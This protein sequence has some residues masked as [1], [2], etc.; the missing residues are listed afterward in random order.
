[1]RLVVTGERSTEKPR[2]MRDHVSP[3][4]SEA[5]QLFSEKQ[6]S[7]PPVLLKYAGFAWVR[8]SISRPNRERGGGRVGSCKSM[9]YSYRL[10]KISQ[11]IW[12]AQ[13]RQRSIEPVML[14]SI[15]R[16]ES[17]CLE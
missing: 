12:L 15:S 11:G 4:L 14:N 3:L 2:I 7:E 9:I 10:D 1:M 8:T 16:P 13:R 6:V 5:R 17:G